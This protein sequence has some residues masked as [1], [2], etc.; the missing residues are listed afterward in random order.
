LWSEHVIAAVS[1]SIAL[2][3]APKEKRQPQKTRL[4]LQ[5]FYQAK[6]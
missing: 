4:A 6:T 3:D 1:L 2:T 5:R